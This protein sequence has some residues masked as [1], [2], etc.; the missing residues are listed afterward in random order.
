M[1]QLNNPPPMF[2]YFGP[3]SSICSLPWQR[4]GSHACKQQWTITKSCIFIS[5][6]NNKSNLRQD[7]TGKQYGPSRE[8]PQWPLLTHESYTYHSKACITLNLMCY[9]HS[10]TLHRN[11][12]KFILTLW[13]SSDFLW[14]QNNPMPGWGL[15]EQPWTD[16]LFL[17][18][19]HSHL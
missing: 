12:I 18:H 19:F 8:T 6:A 2:N 4:A 13:L 1:E 11:E 14:N 3:I 16:R 7:W 9:K 17:Y 5:K 10:P 15:T